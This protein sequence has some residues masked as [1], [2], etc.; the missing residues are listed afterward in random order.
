MAKPVSFKHKPA[1]AS[2]ATS[3]NFGANAPTFTTNGRVLAARGAKKGS[4]RR[5][6]SATGGGS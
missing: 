1:K 4:T 5:T 3:F 2:S 6:H